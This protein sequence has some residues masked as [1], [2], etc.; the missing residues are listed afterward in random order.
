MRCSTARKQICR[1]L[2]QDLDARRVAALK[3]HL[4]TCPD[5][6]AVENDLR[7][8]VES[9]ARSSDSVP[10]SSVW[11]GI[12]SAL[13]RSAAGRPE[14]S[15]RG[16]G[17]RFSPALRFAAVAAVLILVFV[18][19]ML[20][21]PR[22]IRHPAVPAVSFEGPAYTLAKLEEAEHHYRQAIQALAQAA[23]SREGELDPKLAEV[24]RTNL[25]LIN[26]SIRTCQ[27]AVLSDPSDLESRRYLLAAYRD[28][29]ELL[30]RFIHMNG[31]PSST[32]K[33]KIL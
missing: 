10:P 33:D 1:W 2:D 9:A 16:R 13:D 22:L 6:R 3:G 18:G 28:K 27:E 26:A 24:F 32:G 14:K 4:D 15:R 12:T 11:A 8:I 20:V 30:N 19:G 5:C 7:R 29:T 25:E 31:G 21:G 17:L 23:E